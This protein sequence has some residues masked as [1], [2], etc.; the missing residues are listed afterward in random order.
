MFQTTNQFLRSAE[1]YSL[2]DLI[3]GFIMTRICSF[4]AF[5]REYAITEPHIYTHLLS[6]CR[7]NRV[8]PC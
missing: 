2:T 1:Q 7:E 3:G 4:L 8:H 6:V 5:G